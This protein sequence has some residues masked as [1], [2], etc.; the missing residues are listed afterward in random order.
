M[1]TRAR[2]ALSL[3]AAFIAGAIGG[4]YFGWSYGIKAEG[5]SEIVALGWASERAHYF[6]REGEVS[7]A[8]AA[9][10][11]YLNEVE[12]V[13]KA[14]G[15]KSDPILDGDSAF[16]LARLAHLEEKAGNGELAQRYLAEGAR[17]LQM[18]G[19]PDAS[20]EKLAAIVA[21]LDSAK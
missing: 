3:L 6:Y 4:A 13:R 19:T 14:K 12:K 5:V 2:T 18:A 11:F 17:F 21:R 20:P 7:Q 8:R 16:T 1:K 15:G 9:L 10:Q